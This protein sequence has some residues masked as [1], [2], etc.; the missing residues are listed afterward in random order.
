MEATEIIEQLISL[1][2]SVHITSD[3][4]VNKAT[5]RMLSSKMK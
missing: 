5:V 2:A 4:I 1:L 3:A